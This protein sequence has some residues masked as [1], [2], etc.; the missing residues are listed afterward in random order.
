ME[1]LLKIRKKLNLQKESHFTE[2]P[3]IEEK[4][5]TEQNFPIRTVI[6]ENFGVPQCKARLSLLILKFWKMLSYLLLEIS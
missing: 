5:Q 4:S 1:N 6:S 2:N 3:E